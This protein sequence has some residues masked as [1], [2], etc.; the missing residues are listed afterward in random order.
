MNISLIHGF[1]KESEHKNCRK[2]LRTIKE[3]R[4]FQPI[5]NHVLWNTQLLID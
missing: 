5:R 4:E 1:I 3:N 2:G